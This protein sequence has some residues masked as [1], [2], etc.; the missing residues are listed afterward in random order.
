MNEYN[1]RITELE[2]SFVK[3]QKDV[4]ELMERDAEREKDFINQ[5]AKMEIQNAKLKN[6]LELQNTRLNKHIALLIKRKR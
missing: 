1:E 3:L 4:D 5:K 2:H 6:Q